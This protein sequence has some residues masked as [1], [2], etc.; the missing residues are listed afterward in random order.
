MKSV[1]RDNRNIVIDFGIGPKHPKYDFYMDDVPRMTIKVEYVV[2]DRNR[3]SQGIVLDNIIM[4]LLVDA[5][6]KQVKD[7]EDGQEC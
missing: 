6:Q 2:G 3:L 7:Q 1:T 4:P 5:L